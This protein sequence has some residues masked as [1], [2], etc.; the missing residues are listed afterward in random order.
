MR[1][2]QQGKVELTPA[3]PLVIAT[4]MDPRSPKSSPHVAKSRKTPRSRHG[5]MYDV[6]LDKNCRPHVVK[7]SSNVVPVPS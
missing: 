2:M 6:K 7:L 3:T 4:D 1:K 5:I